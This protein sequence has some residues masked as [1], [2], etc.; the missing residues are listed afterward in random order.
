MSL[1]S[2]RVLRDSPTIYLR[3]NER[4]GDASAPDISGNALNGAYQQ[5]PVLGRPGMVPHDPATC[6]QFDGTDDEVFVTKDAKLDPAN[7]GQ[8]TMECVF[9]LLA[10]GASQ[11]L[12]S[13]G[14]LSYQV[15]VSATEQIELL[16]E[17]SVLLLKSA[18][19]QAGRVYHLVVTWDG[20]SAKAIY[21]DGGLEV[22]GGSGVG[23]NNAGDQDFRAGRR[24]TGSDEEF[25]GMI[26]EVAVYADKLLSAATIQEHYEAF[27]A[28]ERAQTTF[29]IRDPL[30]PH[31]VLHQVAVADLGYVHMLMEPSEVSFRVPTNDPNLD[32]YAHNFQAGMACS[33]ERDDGLFPFF[34]I[35]T[36]TAGT[37]GGGGVEFTAKDHVGALLSK[38][39]APIDATPSVESAAGHIR[40]V[41]ALADARAH[42]PLLLD[43]DLD[44]G[45]PSVEYQGQGEYVD[46]FLRRMAEATGWEWGL[47]HEL[48]RAGACSFLV[49]R[50]FQGPDLTAYALWEEGKHFT[51]AKYTQLASA[52]ISNAQAVGGQGAFDLRPSARA[53]TRGH[54]L[55]P[56]RRVSPGLGLQSE[57]NV[58]GLLG[59]RIFTLPNV[60]NEEALQQSAE[61]ALDAPE[62]IREQLS[63][64]L[65]DGSID[66][67]YPPAPGALAT[68]RFSDIL[69]GATLTRVVRVLGLQLDPE[70]GTID[71]EAKVEGKEQLNAIT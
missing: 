12:I 63:F 4:S 46:D 56:T 31:P 17:N 19:I 13:N 8:V 28:S 68:V 15:R 34:G 54:P 1:Y 71:V 27:L 30:P 6:V 26:Q 60:T 3:L 51:K 69:S 36:K 35:V 10:T 70:A 24:S 48:T 2:A 57:R 9:R 55:Q 58:P 49:W 62:H 33:V 40:R 14:A 50:A 61:R 65:V 11:T 22:S 43:L 39:I 47:R 53:S 25:T 32:D 67:N 42:P 44:D 5:G 37:S 64:T 21:L 20:T 41:L 29:Y 38:A 59:S 52:F 45:G 7:D 23:V 66:L 18:P 16:K